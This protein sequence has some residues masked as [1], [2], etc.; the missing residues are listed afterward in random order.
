MSY[1][2]LK[3]I[4]VII[5]V[6][7]D[8][9]VL[10]VFIEFFLIFLRDIGILMIDLNVVKWLKFFFE[11]VFCV[12]IMF[13]LDYSFVNVDVLMNCNILWRFFDF[14]CGVFFLWREFCFNF[15]VVRN[16]LIVERVE[17]FNFI[18]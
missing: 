14:C 2:W 10:K 13:N 3:L 11:F 4:F 6:L 7:G 9:L 17:K 15:F 5:Y 18:C 8:V 16:I 1:N 12:M